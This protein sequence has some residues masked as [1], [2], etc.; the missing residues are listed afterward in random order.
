MK[1]VSYNIQFG[2][3]LDGNFD[4]ERIA[5]SLAGADVVA[6]QEVTRGFDRNGYADVAGDMAALFPDFY[7]VFGAPCDTFVDASIT[8]GRRVERRFQFGNM[9]LS[10]WP[11][12]ATRTLLLPRSRTYDKLNLQRGASEAVIDAPGGALRVYSVH[13]DHVSPDER[14]HQ[15]R[16]LK[17]RVLAF[18]REG[19]GVTG[20]AEFG[21]ADPPLPDE[22]LIMGDFNMQPESPEYIEMTGRADAYYGRAARFEHPIDALD[23]C[24][25]RDGESYSWM[26]PRDHARRMHLDYCFISAGL[27][28]RLKDVRIDNDAL[29]SDHFPLWVEI[30]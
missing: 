12:L 20:A 17:E 30:D 26:D 4:L 25:G 28:P 23:R 1:L 6:L 13:L 18:T 8:G 3:G 2:I 7:W 21:L 14:L 10:R 22:F 9:I 19:G 11:I 15:I 27:A 24:G 29:G 5:A 16:H